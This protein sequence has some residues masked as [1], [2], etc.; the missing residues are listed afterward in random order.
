MHYK[1]TNSQRIEWI[2]KTITEYELNLQGE[3]LLQRCVKWERSDRNAVIWGRNG[4]SVLCAN[5]E[6]GSSLIKTINGSKQAEPMEIYSELQS[7][8]LHHLGETRCDLYGLY[9][10]MP[11]IDDYVDESKSIIRVPL[12][13]VKAPEGLIGSPWVLGI[14]DG[15][16]LVSRVSASPRYQVNEYRFSW[17][18][19]W[20]HEEYRR[21]G[22]ANAV[23][24][25]VLQQIA[26]EPGVAIWQCQFSNA[27]SIALAQSLGF[28]HHSWSF[29]WEPADA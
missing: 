11:L 6:L 3:S 20:T 23:V 24:S 9:Y 15:E 25:A 21:K 13:E 7:V 29:V 14:R 4:G 27:A 18:G 2:E 12:Q 17:V 26:L 5:E 1:D 8:V 10:H 19:V 16:M 28:I 22:L